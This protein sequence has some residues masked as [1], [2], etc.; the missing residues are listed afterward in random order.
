M[1]RNS[2]QF[3]SALRAGVPSPEGN[4]KIKSLYGLGTGVVPSPVP[5][6]VYGADGNQ[7]AVPIAPW[8]TIRI[9]LL[10][11]AAGVLN[12]SYLDGRGNLMAPKVRASNTLEFTGQPANAEI[13]DLGAKTYTMEAAL[14]NVDG[15]IAIGATTLETV[16]NI[17]AA[18]TLK[19]TI[20]GRTG[21]GTAYAA[22]MTLNPDA[23]AD[24]VEAATHVL[25][26][27]KNGGVSGN[28]LV[29]TE[30]LTNAVW[31][32]LG[33]VLADGVDGIITVDE[34]AIVADTPLQ[35]EIPGYSD[36][37]P[38]HIGE[39][40]LEISVGELV[41]AS[42]ATQFDVMGSSW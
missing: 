35:V 28:A 6:D 2:D 29:A 38:E 9:S 1:P 37:A 4:P 39:P 36:A 19:D 20:D 25:C 18:I 42:L 5:Q 26:T 34:T 11:N 10:L 32:D 17:I 8:G 3:L 14:T 7:R 30:A 13:F 21:P 27:A 41:A 15:N 16:F 31:S 23:T 22:A 12:L 40:Y 33:G 24:K